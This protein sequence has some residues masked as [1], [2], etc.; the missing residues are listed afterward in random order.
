VASS[1][2]LPPAAMAHASASSNVI[3]AVLLPKGPLSQT[4]VSSTF[5]LKPVFRDIRISH[6]N[7]FCQQVATH[8]IM[9]FLKPVSKTV[10]SKTA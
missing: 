6:S 10:K 4:S 2:P 3:T 7:R 5:L 9:C 1:H 8:G